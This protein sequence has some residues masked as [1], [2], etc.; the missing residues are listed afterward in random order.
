MEIKITKKAKLLQRAREGLVAL[1]E[2]NIEEIK[3]YSRKLCEGR[4]SFNRS[5]FRDIHDRHETCEREYNR[6][7]SGNDFG[8]LQKKYDKARYELYTAIGDLGF[9]P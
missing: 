7:G 9:T 4:E 6:L 8:V 5:V 1:A 3:T 2:L